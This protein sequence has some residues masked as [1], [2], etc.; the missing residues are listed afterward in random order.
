MLHSVPLPSLLFW[1]SQPKESSLVEATLPAEEVRATSAC[2]SMAIAV[3]EETLYKDN[4]P[5]VGAGLVYTPPYLP[6]VPFSVAYM[7]LCVWRD[8]A[9][10]PESRLVGTRL[11]F[12]HASEASGFL[13]VAEGHPILLDASATEVLCDIETSVSPLS[14]RGFQLHT[15]FAPLPDGSKAR[16]IV[17]PRF[18][19]GNTSALIPYDEE[20][21]SPELGPQPP[22]EISLCAPS[23]D[24]WTIMLD[25]A[26]PSIIKEYRRLREQAASQPTEAGVLHSSN[27]GN[28]AGRAEA[29][30]S[31]ERTLQTVDSI[32]DQAHALQLQSMADLGCI[33]YLDRMLARTLMAEFSRV[34][35]IVLEDVSKS[36]VAL[37]SDLL[38]SSSAFIADVARVM[39]LTP[40]DP[41]SALLRASLET[42]RRQASLKFDLPLVEM[43][44]AGR[45]ITTFM[46][47]RLQELSS[48]TELPELIKETTSVM[49]LHNNRIRELVRNPDLDLSGVSSRVI[50]GLLAR[51]PIEADLF[52]GILEGLAGNLGLSPAGTVNPPHSM[53]EGMMRR[54]AT[55]LR[56][57][58]YD[59]SGTGQGSASSTTPLGLH[60]NYDMEFRS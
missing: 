8:A 5:L 59:P 46:N 45:V 33:R 47:A 43:E 44:V 54:W 7:N 40:A 11:M 50:L 51:Q 34:Q 2:R 9:E 58:A 55:A 18:Q 16:N 21:L 14:L 52:P 30:P 28:G 27:S 60:L 6:Q 57:A 23:E 53:Q 42:F 36:L 48:Q 29:T 37:Q 41:R 49:G 4:C 38:D 19:G 22:T 13:P 20:T 25:T 31:R 56:Q 32:L 3:S 12:I 10:V 24:H 1:L 17:L 26:F 35:L 39:G 15:A